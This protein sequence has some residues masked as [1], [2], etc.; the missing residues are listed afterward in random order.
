MFDDGRNHK[1]QTAILLS[2]FVAVAISI[3]IIVRRSRQ[4]KKARTKKVNKADIVWFEE[5]KPAGF[6][7]EV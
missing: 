2:V 4:P 5:Q 6:Q 1:N 3:P 7:E